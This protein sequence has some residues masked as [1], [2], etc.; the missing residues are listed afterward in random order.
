[1]GDHLII[2]SYGLLEAAEAK[3]LQP[4]IVYLDSK[5]KIKK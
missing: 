2:L 1:V 5:N 3:G 4:K